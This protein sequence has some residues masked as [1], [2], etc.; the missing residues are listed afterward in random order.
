MMYHQLFTGGTIT[1]STKYE[2]IARREKYVTMCPMIGL[3]GS[4]IGNMTIEGEMKVGGARPLCREH[5]TGD[6]SFWE[7]LSVEFATRR[8]D[9]KLEKGIEIIGESEDDPTIQMKYGYEVLSPG[10]QLRHSFICTSNDPLLQSAFWRV[11]EL[12]REH[13][14]IGG[15]SAVGNGEIAMN[16][17]VPED[18]SEIYR[19]YLE[20]EKG[21]IKEYFN[22]SNL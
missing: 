13:P 5:G 4:A 10:T 6:R 15:S 14:F 19:T 2:D 3:F 18:G 22:G 12:F 7:L 9:S 20:T 17:G 8:D 1:D 21:K 16:Y 11:L